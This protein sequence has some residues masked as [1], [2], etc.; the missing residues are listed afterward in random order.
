VTVGD[1]GTVYF[2]RDSMPFVYHEE[3]EK[4]KSTQHPQHPTWTAVGDVGHVDEEGYLFLTDRTS[5]MII[6]GGVNIYPQEVE[7]ALTLHPYIADLGP[8]F[9]L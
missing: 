6:S 7:N 4:T 5:F 8:L 2:E 1:T 9:V 3:E